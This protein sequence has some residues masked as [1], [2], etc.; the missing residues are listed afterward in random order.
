MR[1]AMA[2]KKCKAVDYDENGMPI[3]DLDSTYTNT[4]W[5]AA[6]RLS[7]SNKEEDKKKL[8]EME[9]TVLYKEEEED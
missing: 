7:R 6:S 1:I 5:L 3:F 2:L 4:N 9:E 8:K